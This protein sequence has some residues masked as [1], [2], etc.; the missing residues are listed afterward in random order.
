MKSTLQLRVITPERQVLD[1]AVTRV[2]LREVDGYITLLPGHAALVAE[3]GPGDMAFETTD[4]K[5]HHLAVCGGFLQVQDDVVKVLADSALWPSEINLERAREAERR[6]R[7]RV[8][9]ADHKV[10]Y[11]RAASALHRAQVRLEVA[12]N[13][14][15]D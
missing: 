9:G 7:E 8:F 14:M 3:L 13:H 5:I 10:D 15:L 6:A 1:E 11:R 12:T 4:G 2:T